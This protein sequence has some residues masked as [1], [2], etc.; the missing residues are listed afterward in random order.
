MKFEFD[1]TKWEEKNG[2]K[3]IRV[4]D[5]S[6]SSFVQIVEVSPSSEVGKH[7]H[8]NQT[9]VFYI[10]E[11]SAILGLGGTEYRA[12]EGDIFLCKPKTIHYVINNSQNRFRV[13]VFKYNWVKNDS[14]WL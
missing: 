14:V 4:F 6:E 8:R 2:Y 5:I 7:Y 12:K 1:E 13:L 3:T 10:L 11:G 9:E